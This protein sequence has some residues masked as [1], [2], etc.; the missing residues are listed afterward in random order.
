MPYVTTSSL[1]SACC[2]D[3]PHAHTFLIALGLLPSVFVLG[4]LVGV[5]A[6][7]IED[8]LADSQGF[9]RPTEFERRLKD[10]LRGVRLAGP[11][12]PEQGRLLAEQV[13]RG[14][15]NADIADAL[16]G[17]VCRRVADGT[18]RHAD[19]RTRVVG[20]RSRVTVVGDRLQYGPRGL[21]TFN[22]RFG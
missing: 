13:G 3:G 16:E 20:V 4:V 18:D 2:G 8:D 7:G 9:W 10:D 15:L 11:R 21:Y 1:S 6:V 5:L 19:V 22:P 12:H 14:D 17:P